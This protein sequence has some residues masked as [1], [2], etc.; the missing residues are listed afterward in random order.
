MPQ[1]TVGDQWLWTDNVRLYFF[2]KQDE[3]GE[4]L[5]WSDKCDR[6]RMSGHFTRALSATPRNKK[7]HNTSFHYKSRS[8]RLESIL[9]KRLN[10]CFDSQ[11]AQHQTA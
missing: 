8:I 4:F 11:S 6:I 10:V 3:E 1:N 2:K 7:D 9:Q 5:S